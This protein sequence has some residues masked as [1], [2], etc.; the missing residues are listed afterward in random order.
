MSFRLEGEAGELGTARV[1]V[2]GTVRGP[3]LLARTPLPRGSAIGSASLEVADCDLT[4]LGEPPVRE[5]SAAAGRAPRRSLGSGRI[6]T[7]SLLGGP[8]LVR[9]GQPVELRVEREGL[10]VRASGRARRSGVAGEAVLAENEASGALVLAE[11]QEDG[12]L[13]VRLRAAGPRLRGPR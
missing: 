11:V 1:A 7:P 13:R 4:R 5:V 12:S 6:L 9:R 3:A 8:V 10:T 2:R